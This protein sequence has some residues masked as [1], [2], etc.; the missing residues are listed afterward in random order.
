MIPSFDAAGNLLPGVHVATWAEVAR[1]YG[2][3]PHRQSLLAGFLRGTRILASVGCKA[4]YLDGSYVSTKSIPGDFDACW[5]MRGA[6]L[7]LLM[8]TEPT[9]LD[10]SNKRAAQKAKFKGE[11]FPAEAAADVHRRTFLE[12][13][14]RDRATGSPK[15]IVL[16][17]LGTLP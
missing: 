15:G 1:R 7:K 6:D 3:T 14:Q 12:F 2:T 17:D 11:F 8:K 13:F 10:F 9:L 16:V 4:V 5:E